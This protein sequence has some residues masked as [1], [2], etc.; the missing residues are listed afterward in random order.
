MPSKNFIPLAARRAIIVAFLSSTVL[1]SIISAYTLYVY[2]QVFRA[3]RTFIV[4]I[5]EF[6]FNASDTNLQ[7]NVSIQNPSQSSFDV[8][9]I[10]ERIEVGG[11]FIRNV[12]VYMQDQPLKL[13]PDRN[14]TITIKADVSTKISVITDRLDKDWYVQIRYKLR[15]VLVGEFFHESWFITPITKS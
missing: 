7:T 5:D 4:G 1:F 6:S 10:E 11:I 13:L 3:V 14:L 9:Y 8:L 15:G 2:F 12:G